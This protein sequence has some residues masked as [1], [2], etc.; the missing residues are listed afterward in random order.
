MTTSN[1]QYWPF[2]VVA[3]E[4]RAPQEVDQ[5]AFLK[6]TH[7]EGYESFRFGINDYGAKSSDRE[8]CILERGR[9]RWEIRLALDEQRRLVAF[10]NEFS[11]AAEAVTRW[12]HGACAKEIIQSI[13]ESLVTPPGAKANHR[14]LDED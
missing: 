3:A 7:A 9:N 12:L 14:I 10:V 4:G 5:V 8:G 13:A 11:V 6:A 2:A 1:Y